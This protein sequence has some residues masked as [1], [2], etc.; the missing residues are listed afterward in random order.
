MSTVPGD[1]VVVVVVVVGRDCWLPLP[2]DIAALPHPP[3]SLQPPQP[4][5][6]LP[7]VTAAPRLSLLPPPAITAAPR[8]SLPS[9]GLPQ[10]TTLSLLQSSR[11]RLS[12]RARRRASLRP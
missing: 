2:A 5:L 7:A 1:M 9:P 8:P 4:S 12:P 6:P 3:L 10:S 11:R